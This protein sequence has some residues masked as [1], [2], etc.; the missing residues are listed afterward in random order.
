MS[1]KYR[2]FVSVL[3]CAVFS[4]G[5][6]AAPS[7]TLEDLVAS[8]DIIDLTHTLDHDFPYIPVP[9]VTFG[10][11]LE[12]IATI[13]KMGVAANAWRIHEH[14]GTQI[15][16]PNHFSAG[17]AGLEALQ[18]RALVVPVVV[19][20]FRR[21]SAQDRDAVIRPDDIL[22]WEREHGRI[23]A[24]AVVA[25]YTG[26]DRKIGDAS[27]IGQDE[28]HVKHFPGF[29]QDAVRFLVRERDIW[30]VAVDTISFDV[31]IDGNY[32]A[33]RELLGAGKW[34]LEALKDLALL[35]PRGAT[36]FIGAPKIRDATGGPARVIAF[37][38]KATARPLAMAGT[39]SS[40]GVE[41]TTAPRTSH[42]TR[43]FQFDANRWSV[44]FTVF[45]DSH[46][47]APLVRGRN[48]G[49]YSLGRVLP[50]ADAVEAD[51]SFERRTLTPL[52]EDVAA[53]L[54]AAG[55]GDAPWKAG[56][57]QD[58]TRGGCAA[59]RVPS[60]SQC[61]REYDL[62]RIDAGQLRLGPR[63]QDSDLCAP[64]RRPAYAE[65]ASLRR[66]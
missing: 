53:R 11:A 12:P 64:Q 16:A 4:G 62:V 39:W 43:S 23:P 7:T 6:A 54:T 19:I 32:A 10:F 59:F 49:S 34:A 30:G 31:G 45:A 47:K 55:C 17:G 57:A 25:L 8:S 9:G 22:R 20:D 42:L 52:T 3:A 38:P 24:N 15:D 61:P 26:W 50:L 56:Q 48:E 1:S 29:G 51:F 37:V 58:V 14:I 27:F 63:P 46:G 13:E 36:L 65:G 41:T 44:E 60:A 35:P 33:H 21:Q 2:R 40:H 66:Q 5:A 28:K 18:A